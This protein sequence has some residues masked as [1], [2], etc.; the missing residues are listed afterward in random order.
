MSSH[1]N[2][3]KSLLIKIGKD[4]NLV[5]SNMT[6]EGSADIDVEG[7]ANITTAQ[8]TYKYAKQQASLMIEIGA[9][10]GNAYLYNFSPQNC[11]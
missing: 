9:K 4:L 3:G 10:I 6:A 8:N 5:A 2:S 11:F 7:N 1:I